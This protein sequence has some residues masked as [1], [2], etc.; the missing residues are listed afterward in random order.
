MTT[1]VV[2][3]VSVAIGATQHITPVDQN[4]NPIAIGMCSFVTSSLNGVPALTSAVA[5]YVTDATGFIFT[6]V[7]VG[8]GAGEIK[9]VDGN[10]TFFSAQFT[11]TVPSSITAVGTTSP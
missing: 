10:D 1:P 7:G 8:V 5:T 6:G 11:V 3:P 2:A 4:G 9:V